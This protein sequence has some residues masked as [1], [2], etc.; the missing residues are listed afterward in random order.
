MFARP[1]LAFSAASF[2]A[3]LSLLQTLLMENAYIIISFFSTLYKTH[4]LFVKIFN[5]LSWFLLL[6]QY[7]Q[8]FYLEIWRK[9]EP[10]FQWWYFV[11]VLLVTYFM[12]ILISPF[13]RLMDRQILTGI[14]KIQVNPLAKQ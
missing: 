13:L 2:K 7:P 3:Q 1:Y 10:Y 9:S 4:F 12:Y 5:N 14:L 11:A 6:R 8:T